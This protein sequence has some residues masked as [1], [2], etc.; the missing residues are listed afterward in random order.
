MGETG[1]GARRGH[2]V[3]GRF[4]EHQGLG[5]VVHY[6]ITAVGVT[7]LQTEQ[8][9][10]DRLIGD[11]RLDA[12]TAIGIGEGFVHGRNRGVDIL[13]DTECDRDLDELERVDERLIGVE[14]SHRSTLSFVGLENRLRRPTRLDRGDLPEQVV[15]IGHPGIE[16]EAT[17]GRESM[18]GVADE[19][20]PTIAIAL[21]DLGAH[22]P[23]TDAEDLE[24][25]LVVHGGEHD[26]TST[27]LVE[28]LNGVGLG[29][30]RA[31]VDPIG[32]Q[33]MTH[34]GATTGGINDEM[35]HTQVRGRE[36][37]E[38]GGEMHHDEGLDGTRS[39]GFD[40]QPVAHTAPGA[41]GGQQ[42]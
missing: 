21:G 19:K 42:I 39:D 2:V 16:P 30:E 20:H 3:A 27:L 18:S 35:Q 37:G 17:G 12:S 38:I 34:E 26:G 36:F 28:G 41:V 23:G 24:G 15:H 9:E 4:L 5:T 1:S 29:I 8:I 7:Q 31:H 14:L 6:E 32:A 22:V 13:G 11:G 33:P 10:M 40:T 25:N